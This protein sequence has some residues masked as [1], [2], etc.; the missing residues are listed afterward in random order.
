MVQGIRSSVLL[1]RCILP[2]LLTVLSSC[3]LFRESPPPR[4]QAD[5]ARSGNHHG[6]A[7][8]YDLLGDEKN[9]SKLLIVKRER[10]ELASLIK[11]ISRVAADAHKT[12]E[13]LARLDA[14]LNLIDRGLPRAEVAT[15]ERIAKARAKELLTDKGKDFELRLLLTQNEALIYGTHLAAAVVAEEE[16]PDRV[17]FLNRL[18]SDLSSLQQRVVGMLA[19]NYSWTAANHHP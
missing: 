18:S 13:V 17:K 1:G 7:L 10:A 9:V 2:I 16:N 11:D 14:R 8:L 12:I 19:T 15:R 4:P 5:L 3:A 6:Y